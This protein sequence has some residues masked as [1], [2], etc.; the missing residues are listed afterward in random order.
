MDQSDIGW[1]MASMEWADESAWPA[2]LSS[3][4]SDERGEGNEFYQ[5]M[6]NAG[7][8]HAYLEWTY[9]SGD[10]FHVTFEERRKFDRRA[11]IEL[12]CGRARRASDL[13]GQTYQRAVIDR[14][15]YALATG[16]A[17]AA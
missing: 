7:W 14:H 5:C 11:A 15:E 4:L 12:F 16:E 3:R 10:L 13:Q 2:G 1:M 17:L 6:G 8:V 9:E